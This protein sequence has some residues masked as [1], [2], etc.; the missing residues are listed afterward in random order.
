MF[1]IIFLPF[2]TDKLPLY[3]RLFI[4]LVYLFVFYFLYYRADTQVRWFQRLLKF[5]SHIWN[6]IYFEQK[7][8]KQ[9]EQ[10]E[11]FMNFHYQQQPQMLSTFLFYFS[12]PLLI[13]CLSDFLQRCWPAKW[14]TCFLGFPVLYKWVTP[15]EYQAIG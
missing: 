9:R 1:H 6:C 10:L 4:K 11:T 14:T 3:S 13:Y 5:L 12:G 15:E 8:R 7:Y 2:R